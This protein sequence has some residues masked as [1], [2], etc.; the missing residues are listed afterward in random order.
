MAE[1]L[2][3]ILADFSVEIR[4]EQ[5]AIDD[6]DLIREVKTVLEAMRRAVKKRFSMTAEIS[7][8]CSNALFYKSHILLVKDPLSKFQYHFTLLDPNRKPEINDCNSK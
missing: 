5:Q 4:T 3:Q 1:S 6:L 8:A 7:E 2:D